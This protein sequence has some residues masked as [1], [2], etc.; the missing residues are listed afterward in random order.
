MGGNLNVEDNF[1]GSIA[2][3]YVEIDAK[4]SE[5]I[6]LDS[7]AKKIGFLAIRMP[8]G[9]YAKAVMMAIFEVL[10][11]RPFGMAG[12]GGHLKNTGTKKASRCIT[13]D[14]QY[15]A[16]VTLQRTQDECTFPKDDLVTDAYSRK[17]SCGLADY[18][19]A[20]ITVE[21]PLEETKLWL[22]ESLQIYNCVDVETYHICKAIV[23]REVSKHSPAMQIVAG[24]FVSDVVG[25]HALDQKIDVENAYPN[26][27]TFITG[28]LAKMNVEKL[29]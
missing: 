20:A 21:S 25:E 26:L 22:E 12:A 5:D 1:V 10:N 15:L 27:G 24:L 11:V 2:Y 14:F 6:S 7:G 28:L 9:S 8:N 16:K 29:G 18:S 4:S 13:G 23:D 17:D 3:S 19:D